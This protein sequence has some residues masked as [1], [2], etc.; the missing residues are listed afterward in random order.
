MNQFAAMD[1][2]YH[3]HLKEIGATSDVVPIHS[4]AGWPEPDMSVICPDRP[5]AP[6]MTEDKFNEVFGD[7]ATWIRNAS[8]AKGAH[9]DYVAV[10]LLVT[11]SAA[12]GNARWAV[13]WDGWK[14]PPVL[15]GALV[16][17]PSAGKSPA[18]D[19]ILD[20]VRTIER[21]LT[22]TYKTELAEWNDRNE[23][24][25]MIEGEWKKRTKEA[26]AEGGTPPEKPCDAD[27]GARPVRDRVQISD[28]TTEK[29]ADLLSSTWRGLLLCRDELSG[30]IGSMDRYNG[31]GDRPFWLEAYGGRAYSIDRKSSPEPITVEHLTVA[32]I[33]GTQPDKLDTLL[34]R[35]DD[36]GLLA[37]FLTVYP[38]P[39]PPKRPTEN[40]DEETPTAALKRLRSLA[41]AV[42][43]SGHKRPYFIHLTEE[44]RAM[45]QAFR[46]QCQEWETEANGLLRGHIGKMPGLVVRVASVL[47]HLDWAFAANRPRVSNI[48]QEH[49]ARA[50]HYVGEHLRGHAYRAYGAAALPTEQKNARKLAEVIVREKLKIVRRRDIQ[51]RHLAG[52][53]TADE[54]RRAMDVL[55]DA[56]WLAP[57]DSKTGGRSRAEYTVNPRL[58]DVK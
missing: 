34:V 25:G 48:E 20:P 3:K 7:W 1:G 26:I 42:D 14:E 30:W 24:A 45:L 44:G 19:A 17:N 58:E 6:E 16:G 36:D 39:V 13:P 12:I 33:G 31:G 51:R 47:A 46:L 55:V 37:R 23:M 27:P 21:E 56:D 57:R 28:A 8:E 4:A 9:P 53:Q 2:Q 54:L 35:T 49:I 38:K 15:W 18:L 40:L 11:A 10:S 50:R 41:P 52:L 5:D 43:E 22:E 29:V 32:V